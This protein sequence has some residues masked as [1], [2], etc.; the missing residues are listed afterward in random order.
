MVYVINVGGSMR[1]G[2]DEV[3]E[4]RNVR[5]VDILGGFKLKRRLESIGIIPDV[6]IKKVSNQFMK[7][8]VVLAVGKTKIAIG[9][10]MA[11]KI[12]VEEIDGGK[13]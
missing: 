1:K 7:G 3:K 13:E 4:G 12:I 11:K 6:I 8:P 10:G 9:Y 2:L 5:V